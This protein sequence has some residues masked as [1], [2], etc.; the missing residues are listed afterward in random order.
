MK[1]NPHYSW[2]R[3]R[4]I[5]FEY[6]RALLQANLIAQMGGCPSCIIKSLNPFFIRARFQTSEI[7]MHPE[8]KAS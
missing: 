1:Q 4:G 5:A 2:A 3:L 7:K 6:K 8:D